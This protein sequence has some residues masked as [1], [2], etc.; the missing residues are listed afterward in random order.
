MLSYFPFAFSPIKWLK[1][2]QITPQTHPQARR[3]RL[4]R[5]PPPSTGPGIKQS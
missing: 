1:L 4:R 3:C 2:I 5:W